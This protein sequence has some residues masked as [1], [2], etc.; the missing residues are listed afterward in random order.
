MNPNNMS[1]KTNSKWI[2]EHIM[3]Q[4][5]WIVYKIL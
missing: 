4:Y 2:T 3:L 5:N 1:S